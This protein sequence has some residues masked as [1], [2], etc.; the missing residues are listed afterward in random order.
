MDSGMFCLVPELHRNSPKLL[1]EE[2][3]L[4]ISFDPRNGFGRA[5]YYWNDISKFLLINILRILFALKLM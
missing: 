2:L 4:I 3:K 1:V 5:I